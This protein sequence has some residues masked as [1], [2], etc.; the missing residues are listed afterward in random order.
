MLN[1]IYATKLA[2]AERSLSQNGLFLSLG[3]KSAVVKMESNVDYL[4]S[5][6]V[7]R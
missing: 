7:N 4:Y 6:S 2:L 3:K 5:D 1:A